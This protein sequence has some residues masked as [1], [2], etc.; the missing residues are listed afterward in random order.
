MLNPPR[1]KMANGESLGA[2][3]PGWKLLPLVAVA[4][5]R[6]LAGVDRLE[7]QQEDELAV[8]TSLRDLRRPDRLEADLVAEL[9]V[10]L[11]D[12]GRALAVGDEAAFPPFGQQRR[13]GFFDPSAQPAAAGPLRHALALAL[14]SGGIRSHRLGHAASAPPPA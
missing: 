12:L 1:T 13:V 2:L 14:P 4:G 11:D 5:R 8:G 10:E 6:T 9:A 3:R 7:L